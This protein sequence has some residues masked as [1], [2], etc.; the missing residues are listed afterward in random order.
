MKA[1][2]WIFGAFGNAST[3]EANHTF[4]LPGKIILLL[5]FIIFAIS[6]GGVVLYG[7]RWKKISPAS[8]TDR[9]L[10]LS[11]SMF[12]VFTI[13]CFALSVAF[14]VLSGFTP[15]DMYHDDENP[16]LGIADLHVETT[17]LP[18][19][20]TNAYNAS[21]VRMPQGIFYQLFGY[22]AHKQPHT[23]YI[24]ANT[25]EM[26]ADGDFIYARYLANKF[27]NFK[28]KIDAGV[29]FSCCLPVDTIP[30]GTQVKKA[31]IV[32]TELVTRFDRNYQAMHKRL[33]VVKVTYE[34]PENI[35]FYIETSSS[36]L[37]ALIEKP[38]QK[39]QPDRSYM[40]QMVYW[41]NQT[42]SMKWINFVLLTVSLL[43]T[44]I[45]LK[46]K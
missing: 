39:D 25:G 42:E 33:P 36:N 40:A 9:R 46:T 5:L 41:L 31:G 3:V 26:L 30:D 45:L 8:R 22:D 12:V 37:A 35:S 29:S 11:A 1:F 23:Y 43:A 24:H 17:E 13:F 20:E 38:R 16:I 7:W 6:V 34:K 14:R 27:K 28:T 10:Q 19:Q 18:W 4:S 15:D 44:L 32:A 21:V 2:H